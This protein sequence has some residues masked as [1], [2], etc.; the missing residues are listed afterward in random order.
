VVSTDGFVGIP[1]TCHELM[2]NVLL[3]SVHG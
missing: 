3:V 1:T 2:F